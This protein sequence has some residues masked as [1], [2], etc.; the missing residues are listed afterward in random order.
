[1]GIHPSAIKRTETALLSGFTSTISI[2]GWLAASAAL[3]ASISVSISAICRRISLRTLLRRGSFRILLN[4]ATHAS[5]RGGGLADR[6]RA[7]A[8]PP[9]NCPEQS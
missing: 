1:M 5:G 8:L 3:S 6:G 9:E 2:S 4:A 7:Q